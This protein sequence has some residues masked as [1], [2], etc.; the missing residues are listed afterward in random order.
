MIERACMKAQT[1]RK[2]AHLT[3]D[4]CA[5]KLGRQLRFQCSRKKQHCFSLSHSISIAAICLAMWPMD[6]ISNADAYPMQQV[7]RADYATNC[8]LGFA[9]LEC[10]EVMSC[11]E[12]DYC[13]GHGMCQRG[14]FCI[15]DPGW[16]VRINLITF[17]FCALTVL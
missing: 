7:R 11:E 1:C 17:L 2:Q 12:L 8:G 3:V 14:G 5:L 13:N 10:N 4:P 15:C 16:A 6:R 9:G